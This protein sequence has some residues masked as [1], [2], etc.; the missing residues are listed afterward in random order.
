MSTSSPSPSLPRALWSLV[1]F[2]V[3]PLLC[4]I[5]VVK[6][7]RAGKSE[8]LAFIMFAVIGVGEILLLAR[9]LEQ[10]WGALWLYGAIAGYLITWAASLI[11]LGVVKDEVDDRPAR[12]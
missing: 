4:L 11:F 9:I 1:A 8:F 6:C 7:Y 5:W 3:F 10:D 12:A 2:L